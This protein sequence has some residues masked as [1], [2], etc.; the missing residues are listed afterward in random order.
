MNIQ[1]PPLAPA[2]LL[3][4]ADVRMTQALDNFF[5][6]SHA[7]LQDTVLRAISAQVAPAAIATGQTCL[8]WLN[9]RPD[10][11]STAFADQFRSHLARPETFTQRHDSRPA[12]LQLL[13]DNALKR[14][15]AEEKAATQLTE[16]LRADM[17]LLFGRLRAVRR[18]AQV[19]QDYVDAYGPRPIIRA[20]SRALDALDIESQCGTLLLQCAAAPLLDTLKHTYAA[21]NQFLC[22]Q[23]VPELPVAH[24]VPPPRHTQAGTG[25]AILAHIESV[26]AHAGE[27]GPADG[28]PPMPRRLIDSLAGWQTHPP[29]AQ[30]TAARILQPLQQDARRAGTGALDLAVLEAVTGLFECILDD[31]DMSPRYKAAIAQ[32]QIPTLRVAL[33]APD[34]FSD[35]QHPARQLIDL[36]GLFSRHFPEHAPSHVPALEQ[37]EARCAAILNDPGH[38]AGAFAQAHNSLAVWLADKNAHAKARLAAE[39]EHLEQIERRELG[40]LLALENLHDLTERY[41]A[42]ESVLRRL[43]AAWVPHMASLYV[44]ESGEGPDWR[45]ACHTLLQLFLS[46]Q[47]PQNDATREARLQS[48][49]SINTALR[50]GLL[51]QG[52]EHGQLKDFF[53][54]I[55]ATQEC[56]IRPAVGQREAVLSTFTPR[57]VSPQQIES[58]ARQFADTPADDP[59]LH[60]TQQLREG[61]WVDFE[62]PCEGLV[63]ARVV[64]VGVH[65]H[66]LFCGGEGEQRF[67]L[68]H[69][70]LAAEIRAGRASIPE[71]SLTGKA[72]LCLKKNLS[73]SPG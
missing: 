7:P 22:T 23:D 15:L 31:P 11:L 20:L 59:V 68:D 58:L 71:Q 61:D 32:L 72:M 13:D 37:I 3:R 12:E 29:G 48:I 1:S 49:P 55:T 70:R 56:W 38:P 19:D 53:S 65:G 60:R 8:D 17:L 14:Q 57:R 73:A 39:V 43:E 64:W 42:P 51:A 46:L 50:A 66:L 34:F 4:E 47:A 5:Q 6:R 16:V 45:A 2:A 26:A 69:T 9:T 18:I 63:S 54:A 24:A 21:L 28:F 33:V 36:I 35:D 25:Q 40:T 10:D 52:A 27:T 67:S 62:P 30:A 44:A 41:P